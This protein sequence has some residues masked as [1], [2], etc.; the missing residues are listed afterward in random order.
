MEQRI[1]QRQWPPELPYDYAAMTLDKALV[2][3]EGAKKKAKQM[4]IAQTVAV[5]DA[6][7]NLVA[8]QRMDDCT[9]LALE[10]AVN[11]ARSSVLGKM[12]T[13]KWGAFFKGTRPAI[14]P[15]WFHSGWITFL[16]GFPVIM[17]GKIIGGIG[18]SGTTWEDGVVAR[19]GLM[20]LGADTSEAEACL[21][22]V[23]VAPEQ[24]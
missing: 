20:A 5:C 1:L 4:G 23:G 14:A 9:L 13:H 17:N 15:L 11:K 8:L 22:D 2:M 21:T 18:C 24:W 7:A 12:A 10:I 3:I 6:A 16:G 19:A